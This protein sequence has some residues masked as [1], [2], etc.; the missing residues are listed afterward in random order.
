MEKNQNSL[1]RDIIYYIP[2][3]VIPSLIGF[4]SIIVY[5]RLLS[6]ENYGIYN[7][8]ITSTTISSNILLGWL[9][10]SS[11]RFYKKFDLKNENY[12]FINS[13]LISVFIVSFSS[14]LIFYST[15][16]VLESF[17]SFR[18]ISFIEFGLWIT[19]LKGFFDILVNIRRANRDSIYYSLYVGSQSIVKFVISLVLLLFFD[20]GINSIFFGIIGASLLIIIYDLYTIKKQNN[21]FWNK[22]DYFQVKEVILKFIRYGLPLVGVSIT[23]SL[24][25]GVQVVF[26][27]GITC[28]HS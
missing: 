22:S 2:S 26:T 1:L 25:T 12:L 6:V 11:L 21:K 7:L 16:N 27:Q 3:R 20:V 10:R 9:A 18:V 15:K 17:I 8:V 4:L 24:T 19:L 13:T 28:C 14:I 5:T 23:G